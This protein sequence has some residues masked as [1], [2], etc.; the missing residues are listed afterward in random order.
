MI[1]IIKN[2]KNLQKLGAVLLVLAIWQIAAM[3]IG[4]QILLASPLSV[5]KRLGTV[6]MDIRVGAISLFEIPPSIGFEL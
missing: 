5:I 2:K 1:S 6:W 3:K 4:Q